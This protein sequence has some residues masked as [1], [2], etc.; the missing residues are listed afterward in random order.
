[1]SKWLE[2]FNERNR[3]KVEKRVEKLKAEYREYDRNYR[4]FPYDRYLK[5]MKRREEEIE[6]LERFGNPNSAKREVEDYKEELDRVRKILG[7]IHY[8]AVNIDP[9]DQKSDANLR[10]L[11]SMTSNYE[12]ADYEFKAKVDAG[13]W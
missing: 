13:I 11:Q 10:K 5:A 12:C 1:M 9:C 4:D 8:L 7:K 6:E 2:N 3:K